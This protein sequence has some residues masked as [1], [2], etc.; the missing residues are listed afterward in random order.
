MADNLW[1]C[2]NYEIY[3]VEQK[4]DNTEYKVT[5][6][7]LPESSYKNPTIFNVLTNE[8]TGSEETDFPRNLSLN[9]FLANVIPSINT[10]ITAI[11]AE[12]YTT[13]T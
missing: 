2:A 13:L 3:K 8:A 7:R 9:N 1:S 11:D 5:F 10:Y 6:Q 12:S 4:N